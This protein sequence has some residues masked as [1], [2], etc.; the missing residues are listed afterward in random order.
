MRR[1]AGILDS[2]LRG[3][4]GVFILNHS[5]ESRNLGGRWR[6]KR[7]RL[8]PE[9]TLF[10]GAFAAFA[11]FRRDSPVFPSFAA[12]APFFRFWR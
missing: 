2:R 6:Q 8:S 12:I 1:T 10:W 7:F 5:G 9:W 4:D 11:D 3:N